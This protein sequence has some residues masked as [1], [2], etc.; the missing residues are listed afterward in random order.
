VSSGSVAC[1]LN[2]ST[3]LL[4]ES[5]LLMVVGTLTSAGIAAARRWCQTL[6]TEPSEPWLA[7]L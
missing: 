3:A 7:L 1:K 6:R 2:P 4:F 5:A